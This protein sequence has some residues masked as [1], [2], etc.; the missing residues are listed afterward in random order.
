MEE[1]LL[2]VMYEVPSDPNAERV[3]ITRDTVLEKVYPT[4]VPRR[5]I[6]T[7]R[8]ARHHREEKTA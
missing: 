6:S 1:V 4:I 7:G 5:D 3:L 8:R 2:S